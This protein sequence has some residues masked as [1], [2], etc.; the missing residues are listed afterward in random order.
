[1]SRTDDIISGL[2]AIANDYSLFAIIWHFI[3]YSLIVI[4]LLKWEPS[5]KLMALLICLPLFS[6]AV[7]AWLSG[8]PFNGMLFSMLT[9]LI[10]IFGLRASSQPISLSQL[11]FFIIGLIMIVFG[12]VYPHFI[13]TSSVIK[14]LYA[15]PVGLIPCPTLS[16]LIGFILL[17]NGFGSQSITLTFIIFGLF[18][19]VFGVLKLAVYLD[20]FLVFGTLTLLIRYILILIK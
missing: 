7:F 3:F 16:I 20:F 12:L 2:H 5:N 17:F 11:P 10:L 13:E 15:S 1:M 4:L 14:Y 19:G 6:V 9:I 18:Y 8:N